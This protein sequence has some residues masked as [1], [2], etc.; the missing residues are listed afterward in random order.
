[1]ALLAATVVLSGACGGEPEPPRLLVDGSLARVASIRFEGADEPVLQTRLRRVTARLAR[2]A[3]RIGDCLRGGWSALP[4]GPIVHRVGVDGES[5]TFS[6]RSHRTLMACDGTR[7]I[8]KRRW[9]GHVHGRLTR[10][11]LRD[12]RLDLGG[13]TNEDG[14][15]I[16]FVWITP[17]PRARYVVVDRN[18][19]SE[20]Y[21]VTGRVPIRVASKERLDP[22]RSSAVVEVSE[23]TADGDVLRTHELEARVAG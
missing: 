17:G 9:C 23:H 5:A 21:K 19:F 13:C 12:P 22:A 2:P 14:D 15:R 18:G 3:S 8:A 16:A 1:V 10:G 6:D 11:R 20:S 7:G 4:D